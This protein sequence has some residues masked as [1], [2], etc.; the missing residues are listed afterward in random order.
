MI[1]STL[2]AVISTKTGIVV[3]YG[4]SE[5]KSEDHQE[6]PKINKLL[7]TFFLVHDFSS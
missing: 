1:Q 5:N 3:G 4:K 6:T 7:T 2:H